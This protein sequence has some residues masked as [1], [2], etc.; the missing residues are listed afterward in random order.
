MLDIGENVKLLRKLKG[1]SQTQLSDMTGTSSRMIKFIEKGQKLPS[2]ALAMEL[3]KVF[4]CSLD[5]LTGFNN[6]KEN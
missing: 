3:A 2:L 5:T 4:D 1:I 6:R